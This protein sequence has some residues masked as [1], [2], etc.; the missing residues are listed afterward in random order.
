MYVLIVELVYWVIKGNFN[1][2]LKSF[3][4]KGEMC[5]LNKQYY[6]SLLKKKKLIELNEDL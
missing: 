3:L 5:F 6:V 4:Y 1:Y 2:F